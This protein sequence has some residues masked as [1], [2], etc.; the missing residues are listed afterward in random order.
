[1][2]SHEALQADCEVLSPPSPLPQTVVPVKSEEDEAANKIERILVVDP[3]EVC[4]GLLCQAFQLMFP[5]AVVQEAMSSADA[6]ALVGPNERFD[7]IVVEER[8]NRA[9]E[10]NDLLGSGSTLMAGI[11]GELSC[12]PLFIGVTSHPEVDAPQLQQHGADVVW[13][14]PPP[15]INLDLRNELLRTLSQKRG[16]ARVKAPSLNVQSRTK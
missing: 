5:R 3:H 2:F 14:K 11:R 4:L 1:M 8:L 10:T 9:G 13:S 16:H 15:R 7:V 12:E 6:L